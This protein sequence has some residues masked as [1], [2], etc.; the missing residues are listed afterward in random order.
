MVHVQRK[1][2]QKLVP[3][4]A[5]TGKLLRDLLKIM[6]MPNWTNKFDVSWFIKKLVKCH[7]I[8]PF[9]QEYI[10]ISSLYS[11]MHASKVLIFL[12][13]SCWF[14]KCLYA[15]F[16][17]LPHGYQHPIPCLQTFFVRPLND[18]TRHANTYI[19]LTF[20]SSSQLI[21]IRE[22][23]CK[24]CW[25]TNILFLMF[26]ILF[27]ILQTYCSLWCRIITI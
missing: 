9:I 14:Q 21:L 23:M 7:L 10:V 8:H 5:S 1:W 18:C 19:F 12:G 6:G 15:C 2:S 24:L 4:S 17:I 25:I 27:L 3:Q 26:L 20:S 16:V 13:G 22:R 11:F